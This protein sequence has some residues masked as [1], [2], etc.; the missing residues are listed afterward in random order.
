[1]EEIRESVR[2]A[3]RE[4]VAAA[5]VAPVRLVALTGSGAWHTATLRLVHSRDARQLVATDTVAVVSAEP[6]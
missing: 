4:S 6:P 2:T 5:R 3:Y 1:M